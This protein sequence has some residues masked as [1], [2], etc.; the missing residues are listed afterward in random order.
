MSLYL[1]ARKPKLDFRDVSLGKE[2]YPIPI[3]NDYDDENYP[4]D[5]QYVVDYVESTPMNVNRVITNLQVCFQTFVFVVGGGVV[6]V[7]GKRERRR[8]GLVGHHKPLCSWIT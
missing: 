1:D 2:Q 3:V 6:F 8:G 4:T 5:Y 7:V